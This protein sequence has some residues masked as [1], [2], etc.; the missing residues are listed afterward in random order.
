MEHIPRAQPRSCM[1]LESCLAISVVYV[2]SINMFVLPAY[3]IYMHR[4]GDSYT[5]LL[6]NFAGRE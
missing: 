2:L 6:F 4:A 3:I 1:L 5:R